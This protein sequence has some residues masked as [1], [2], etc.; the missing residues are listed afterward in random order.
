MAALFTLLTAPA[1]W[2]SVFRANN[3]IS[4]MEPGQLQPLLALHTLDLSS[5]NMVDVRPDSFPLL[6]LRNL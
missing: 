4:R 5:N 1:C 6:P 2:L 3:R